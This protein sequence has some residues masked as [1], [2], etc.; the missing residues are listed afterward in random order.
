[1]KKLIF[2]AMV[3]IAYISNAQTLSYNDIGVLFSKEEIN[4]TAR[5]NAMSGAFGALG[6]DLSSIGINPAG[7]AVFMNSEFSVSLG[8]RNSTTDATYYGNTSSTENDKTNLSQAGGVFV[9][10]SGKYS[11]INKIA[12]AFNYSR[13]NDFENFWNVKGNNGSAAPITDIY[14][15]EVMYDL[16]DGQ[17]FENFTDGRNDKYSFT[18][19]TQ[20]NEDLYL[21]FT[22]NTYDIEHYQTTLLEEYNSDSDSNTFDISQTQELLTYGE[23]VSFGLGLISKPADN[24]RLGLAYQS[25]VWYN[26]SEESIEYDVNIFENDINITNEYNA[27]DTYSGINGFDY[28]LRTPSKLTGSFAYIFDKQGLISIDYTYKNYSNIELKNANFTSENQA[29]QQDL[30]STG[31]L[32]IGTEWRFDKV[33]LRGGYHFEKSPYKNAKDSD[34]LEGYS[35][36]AGFKFRGGKLDFAYQKETNTAPYNFN[37]A[38]YNLNSTELDFNNSKITATLVLSL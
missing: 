1:M 25:P 9:F 37:P 12:I 13:V 3:C 8:I 20:R 29:F 21:G 33:S 14:D 23:G 19:A 2:A 15:S 31:E 18:I 35:L 26:I 34:N 10:D 11:D 38:D 30:E 7:A 4:G 22:L 17:Y 5:Y 6:G 27:N 36:G 16:I 28:K 24:M 32:R